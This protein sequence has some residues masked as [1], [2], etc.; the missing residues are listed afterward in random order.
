M[1]DKQG[2]PTG[3]IDADKS[4]VIDRREHEELLSAR[5]FIQIESNQQAR[6]DYDGGTSAVYSG[7]APRGLTA[8]QTG[9]LLQKFTYDGNGN[10]TLRQIAYDSWD[11]RVTATYA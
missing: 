5:R 11:N 10:V 6:F 1:A 8:S 4:V 2:V 7:F 9:W 3:G